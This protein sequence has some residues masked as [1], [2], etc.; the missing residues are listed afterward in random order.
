MWIQAGTQ[1]QKDVSAAEG[2]VMNQEITVQEL[3]Q[4]LTCKTSPQ[5]ETMC[6]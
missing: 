3:E 2:V 1:T 6:V 4:N 5:V